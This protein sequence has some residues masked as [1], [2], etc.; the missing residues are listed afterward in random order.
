MAER[1]R[2]A[3][4][5]LAEEARVCPAR[6]LSHVQTCFSLFSMYQRKMASQPDP[7]T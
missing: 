5:I 1:R 4:K 6:P 7:V 2:E 3:L